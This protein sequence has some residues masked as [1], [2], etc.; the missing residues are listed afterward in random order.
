MAEKNY[1][2]AIA[3]WEEALTLDPGLW[4][5]Q[6]QIGE[7]LLA[8]G[9]PAEAVPRFQE[10]RRLRPDDA[11]VK[12]ALARAEKLAAEAKAGP[13]PAPSWGRTPRRPPR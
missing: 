9:R 10:A 8:S 2:A 12:Q 6:Y 11:R 3:Q 4:E 1:A 5:A 7:A 13:T